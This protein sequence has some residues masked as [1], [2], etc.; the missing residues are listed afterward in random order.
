MTGNILDSLTWLTSMI[1]RSAMTQSTNSADTMPHR[2]SVAFAS[3]LALALVAWPAFS[4]RQS[5]PMMVRIA[6]IEVEADS[7]DAYLAILRTEA[8]ASVALEPGVLC[9]F[10]MAEQSAPTRIRLLEIYAS[11]D[12]YESHIR[13]PHFLD[14]KR[15]TLA[16]VNSLRLVEMSPI[17]A[18]TMPALF[19]KVP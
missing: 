10:P 19:R 3:C 11:R 13:S 16:M 7:L 6:E 12:A 15:R 14:Y 5:L 8:A 17:D 2:R 18:G 4:S 1:E 9:L